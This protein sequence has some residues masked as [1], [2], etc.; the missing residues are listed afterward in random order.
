[1]A[2][3]PVATYRVQLRSGFGFNEASHILGYLADLG[4]SHLYASPYFQAAPGSTH[5]YDVVDHVKINTELGGE[6]GH[7]LL[8]RK[9]AQKGMGQILD[10]VPNHMSISSAD[11]TWWWDV[12][13]NG[14]SSRYASYFDVD[15]DPVDSRFAN[16]ILLPILH[17]HFGR[18][19]EAGEIR[20]ERR[21]GAFFIRYREQV[22]P[23]DPSSLAPLLSRAGEDLANGELLFIAD[24]LGSLPLHSATDRISTRRRHRDKEIIR[25]LL[26]R[27]LDE[28]LEAARLVDALIKEL[29]VHPDSLE[30]LLDRQNYRLAFWRTA[31]QDLGYR[32]FFDINSLVGLRMED[33]D[34]FEDSHGLILSWL[35]DGTLDGVRIDHPYGLR[36][37][38]GYLGRLRRASPGTWLIVEKILSPDERLRPD[39]PVDGTTGYEFIHLLTHLLTCP[40]SE[41]EFSAFY[42]E[43]TGE[44]CT[45]EEVLREKRLQVIE[46]LFGSDVNRLATLMLSIC[47][48]HRRY[49]DYSRPEISRA[50]RALIASFPVYRTYV[51]ARAGWISD[52]D[53]RI[54]QKVIDDARGQAS[55]TDPDLIAF[56]GDILLL[57][58]T[59]ELES[60]LVM[61]IQQLTPPVMAKGAEDTAFYCFNRFIAHNEV[62]GDPGSFGIEPGQFHSRMKEGFESYPSMMLATSTHDTKRS[63]DVRAR[64]VL[65]S[66]I[67]GAWFEAVKRWSAMADPYRS[68]GFPD[69]NTEY[70]LY[71]TLVGAWP[72]GI[73]RLLGYM[74]KATREAKAHTS[75]TEPDPAYDEA[76]KSFITGL[77]QD[78][79][80]IADVASFV[81]PLVEP[82][83]I[84]S[85]SQTLIKMTAPGIP[86]IYQGCDLWD[87]SLVDPDNRRP[88]DF[89][90][91]RSL[92]ETLD[93][94]K[95]VQIVSHM[96]TGLPKL[97]VI[98][99][100]LMVRRDLPRAFGEKGSYE[101]IS[102]TGPKE[103]FAF[104]FLRGGEVAVVTQ[105]FVLKRGNSWA[106][107]RAEIP[108]GRWKNVLSGE[109]IAGPSPLMDGLLKTFPAALL[110]KEI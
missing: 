90:L 25:T 79:E 84:N 61:R 9:L 72:I 41:A 4:I 73:E 45:Y 107:T 74:E 103:N 102:F 50:L 31:S 53:R 94:L 106:G 10:I 40:A 85:L 66:E 59:G 37:P 33:E 96:D 101:P 80:F 92:L 12:L 56:I 57:K 109:E 64:L 105:R 17:D 7:E 22:F 39:W 58:V 98:R 21:G 35:K 49:R 29:N 54:I 16:K 6:S 13:E 95:E 8:C 65:L 28:N 108:E 36:E 44:R 34:V 93:D 48:H 18:V 27:I 20:L 14:Q 55:D 1:M 83:R 100:A 87:L 23:V 78:R 11:N 81:E 97:W 2:S 67:P 19:L 89:A 62:G 86:D 52:D 110:V 26:G 104:G 38:A 42:F 99:Q 77:M 91:R 75:W 5:G 24:S 70:F 43:F 68:G 15:W 82:G 47:E 88:V 51:N 32:R 76:L 30:A 63:E 71:Q 60:E 46:K 69:R 3:I